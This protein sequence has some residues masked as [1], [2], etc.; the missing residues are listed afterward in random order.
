MV[1]QTANFILVTLSLSFQAGKE[2][3]S[4]HRKQEHSALYCVF[5]FFC[6][7]YFWKYSLR[8]MWSLKR[9]KNPHLV[10]QCN[11]KP[12]MSQNWTL[13]NGS[14]KESAISERSYGP[15]KLKNITQN[16][17]TLLKYDGVSVNLQII[18][19]IRVF[20]SGSKCLQKI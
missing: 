14:K 18:N 20:M 5:I 19:L 1:A 8:A 10:S 4:C 13:C 11:T 3:C 15:G 2:S 9:N 16:S 6:L 12:S 7:F 17:T